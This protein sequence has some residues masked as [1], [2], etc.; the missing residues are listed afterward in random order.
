MTSQTTLIFTDANF[1]DE[2]LR[3]DIGVLVDVWAEGCS[4]CRKLA[5]AIDTIASEYSGRAKVGKLDAR[6]NLNTALR[7]SVR[8][9]PTLL[10]FKGG[11]VL[12][13]RTGVIDK[14]ELLKLLDSCLIRE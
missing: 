13:Q 11:N 8:V 9:L 7:Y 1:D 6:L 4:G 10:F 5:P 14:A 12:S 2:V 3:S